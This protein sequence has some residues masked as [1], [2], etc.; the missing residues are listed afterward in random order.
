MS[1]NQPGDARPAEPLPK[2]ALPQETRPTEPI[3]RPRLEE[4]PLTPHLEPTYR[5]EQND[6]EPK[7]ARIG[8]VVWG[9]I[10]IA[11]AALLLVSTMGWIV[12]D[13]TYVLIGLMIGA[14][15]ALVVGGLVAARRGSK[16]VTKQH[17]QGRL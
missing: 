1:T 17:Q 5:I 10:V 14:G 2:D 11:L 4:I 3:A 7:Q 15:A 9:L 16:Q 8:T 12:L 13:G 6:D